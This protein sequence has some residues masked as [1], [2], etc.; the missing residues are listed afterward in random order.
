MTEFFIGR[1]SDLVILTIAASL[2]PDHGM[3]AGIYIILVAVFLKMKW[4]WERDDNRH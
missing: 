4:G 3:E 2:I 1:I